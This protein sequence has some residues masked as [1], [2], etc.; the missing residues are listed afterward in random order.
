MTSGLLLAPVAPDVRGECSLDHEAQ[1]GKV[2][3]P[4]VEGPDTKRWGRTHVLNVEYKGRNGTADSGKRM[5]LSLGWKGH[6]VG[7]GKASFLLKLHII[8]RT[9]Q[10]MISVPASLRTNKWA[11]VWV[12]DELYFSGFLTQQHSANRAGTFMSMKSTSHAIVFLSE[13]NTKNTSP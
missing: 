8:L 4:G 6:E 9:H 12:T 10:C 5:G 7:S 2:T 1:H 13:V 3:M 11:L